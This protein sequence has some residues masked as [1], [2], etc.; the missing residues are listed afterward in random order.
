MSI[1]K[2]ILNVYNNPNDPNYNRIGMNVQLE[3][4]IY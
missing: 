4:K 3:I 2:D 1:I